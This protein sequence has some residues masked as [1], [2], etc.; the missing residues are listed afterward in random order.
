MRTD[1]ST[2]GYSVIEHRA[3]LSGDVVTPQ[4]IG[5]VNNVLVPALVKEYLAELQQEGRLA[6]RVGSVT[7]CSASDATK[8]NR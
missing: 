3:A 2:A 1:M 4:L 5:W 6:S 8:D 7:E